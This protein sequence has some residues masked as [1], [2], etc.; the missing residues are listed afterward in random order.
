MHHLAKQW[1]RDSLRGKCLLGYQIWWSDL[2]AARSTN[3]HLHCHSLLHA[4]LRA[5]DVVLA[6]SPTTSYK[7]VGPNWSPPGLTSSML[8]TAM[9]V[10]WARARDVLSGLPLHGA[11]PFNI[12]RVD[13]NKER[14]VLWAALRRQ[15]ICKSALKRLHCCICTLI[16]NELLEF[17]R[18]PQLF[19]FELRHLSSQTSTSSFFISNIIINIFK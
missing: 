14:K 5:Q 19:E 1:S 10:V 16:F 12:L 3:L 11:S 18:A 7:L 17:Y 8:V 2:R 13:T 9:S 4:N 15:R 6:A